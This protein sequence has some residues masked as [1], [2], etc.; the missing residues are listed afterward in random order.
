MWHFFCISQSVLDMLLI[1]YINTTTTHC[2]YFTHS[3][4]KHI[5]THI[6]IRMVLK[7]KWNI[8]DLNLKLK[9][10]KCDATKCSLFHQNKHSLFLLWITFLYS[11]PSEWSDADGSG[12]LN[13]ISWC[14]MA[15]SWN[16]MIWRNENNYWP[17]IHVWRFQCNSLLLT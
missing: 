11:K 1:K 14:V 13:S 8:N 4:Y 12:W 6:L 17:R 15:L 2:T 16:E 3:H 7:L 5:L 9:S 10:I